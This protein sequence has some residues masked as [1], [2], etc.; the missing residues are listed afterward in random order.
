[1][2][3]EHASVQTGEDEEDTSLQHHPEPGDEDD[4]VSTSSDY[5]TVERTDDNGSAAPNAADEGGLLQ[6][7][8]SAM[9]LHKRDGSFICC[10]CHLSSP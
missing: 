7:R 4:S 1:M 6:R 2:K 10:E 5:A 3:F 8:V 9:M